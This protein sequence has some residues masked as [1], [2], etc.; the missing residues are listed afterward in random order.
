MSFGE[1]LL[2]ALALG[3]DTFGVGLSAGA[4]RERGRWALYL[5]LAVSRALRIGDV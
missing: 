2:L 3:L 5:R 1:T 4:A